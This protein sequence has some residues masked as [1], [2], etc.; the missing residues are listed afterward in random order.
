[1]TR[2]VH[3]LLLAGCVVVGLLELPSALRTLGETW[4]GPWAL[5]GAPTARSAEHARLPD[6]PLHEPA[7]SAHP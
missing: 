5:A 4:R 2:R 1:M 6:A 7:G 3:L